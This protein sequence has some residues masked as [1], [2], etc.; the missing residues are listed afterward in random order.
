M[1]AHKRKDCQTSYDL[2]ADEDVRRIVEEV[3]HKP[4]DRQLLDRF[5]ASVRDLGP[6]CDL[7]CGPGHMARYLQDHGVAVC[8]VD[9]SPAMVE[10]ARRLTLGVEFRQG[11]MMTL[12]EADGA[13]AGSVRTRAKFRSHSKI[14]RAFQRTGHYI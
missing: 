2:V 7:G 14:K 9:L 13:W 5:A 8:G 11:D 12:D 1:D 10:R 3:Q 4:L 6:A